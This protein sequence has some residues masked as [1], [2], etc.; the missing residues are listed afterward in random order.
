MTPHHG[1]TFLLVAHFPSFP[2]LVSPSPLPSPNRYQSPFQLRN[3]GIKAGLCH[4]RYSV[5]NRRTWHSTIGVVSRSQAS[6][7][8]RDPEYLLLIRIAQ[9]GNC[10]IIDLPSQQHMK[11]ILQRTVNGVALQKVEK[12]GQKAHWGLV[13]RKCAT[14]RTIWPNRDYGGTTT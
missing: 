12:I 5:I 6:W 2:P 10:T 7:L 13:P 14:R 8:H 3:Q 9:D 1:N 11:V 4:H